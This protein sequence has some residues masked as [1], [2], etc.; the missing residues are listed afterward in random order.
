[1]GSL[2]RGRRLKLCDRSQFGARLFGV[3]DAVKCKQP[4]NTCCWLS[5]AGFDVTG[6]VDMDSHVQSI[7]VTPVAVVL[8][9]QCCSKASLV[10]PILK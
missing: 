4:R 2:K 1:M 3:C 10:M 6:N 7:N 5:C 9:Q 8:P